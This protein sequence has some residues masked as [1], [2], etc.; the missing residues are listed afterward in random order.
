MLINQ[1]KIQLNKKCNRMNTYQNNLIG[2]SNQCKN[3]ITAN[4]KKINIFHSFF[5]FDTSF[6]TCFTFLWDSTTSIFQTKNPYLF[7]EKIVISFSSFVTI[8]TFSLVSKHART[9]GAYLM[10][11]WICSEVFSLSAS[12]K[13]RPFKSFHVKPDL[14][15]S[16][17]SKGP[18]SLA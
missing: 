17:Q 8:S 13:I 4:G 9:F 10:K 6:F 15:T 18:F 12:G 14:F 5:F 1:L 16:L 7:S 3:Q 2:N 11:F